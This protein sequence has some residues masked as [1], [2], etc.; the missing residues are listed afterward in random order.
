[1]TRYSMF[2][3]IE[4]TD[5]D[6]K[7]IAI[8]S[9]AIENGRVSHSTPK[10]IADKI[11]N[12]E[13]EKEEEEKIKDMSRQSSNVSDGTVADCNLMGYHRLIVKIKDEKDGF[14]QDCETGSYPITG[15]EQFV[16]LTK[17]M[18]KQILRNR[19]RRG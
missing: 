4:V 9:K 17:R 2:P 13:K 14:E 3:V 11:E 1:M 12:F 5:S 18:F 16:I 10:Q 15:C 19:V 7:N 6:D 8:L